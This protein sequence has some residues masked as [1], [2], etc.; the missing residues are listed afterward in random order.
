V[1]LNLAY[2]DDRFFVY[3]ACDGARPH[4]AGQYGKAEHLKTGYYCFGN[5]TGLVVKLLGQ[6]R[7]TEA[8]GVACE[9]FRSPRF[10]HE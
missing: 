10:I 1:Q 9:A 2:P 8:F 3:G 4:P 6:Y 5:A 7:I